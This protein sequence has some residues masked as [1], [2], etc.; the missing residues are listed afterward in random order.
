LKFVR[1]IG[2]PRE[3]DHSE[4][5]AQ[6]GILEPTPDGEKIR[7]I[8]GSPL[9]TYRLETARLRFEEV[10]LLAP[11]LPSK[12]VAI[13][14][15]YRAHAEEFKKPPPKEPLIFL[16]PPTA[17]IGPGADIR[18]PPEATRVD[19]EAELGVVIREKVKGIS[20][21][22]ARQ[23]ILGYTCFNDVTARDLQKRD[24]QWTRAKGFDT[25]A[26]TGPC[27]VTDLDPT[28]LAIESAI[29]GTRKQC[30]RTSEMIFDVFTLISYISQVM[31]LLPGDVIA[32]GTPAGV[33]P[34]RRGDR[35]EIVIEG[36]GQL[37]NKVI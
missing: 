7:P 16:K 15:N 9:T 21:Q 1:Y 10:L 35:V 32:T 24:G 13:G 18:Y 2:L 19:L 4:K 22:Q 31:T 8:H 30:A 3:G 5:N 17:V 28:D 11:V 6:Y 26:P 12:I 34:I 36:I 20:P 29:N 14:V 25:F 27:I 37:Q 23:A 33:S